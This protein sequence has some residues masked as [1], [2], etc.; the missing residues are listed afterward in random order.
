MLKGVVF[1]EG[2]KTRLGNAAVHNKRTGYTNVTDNFGLFDIQA[3]EGDTL[4][5]S[6]DGY[7]SK[8][9]RVSNLQSLV[10]YL[11]ISSIQLKEVRITGTSEK[12]R[13]KEVESLYRQ[14]GIFYK[15]KPPIGMLSPLGGSPLGYLYE[16]FSKSGREARRLGAY[17]ERESDYNEVAKRFG[18]EKIR[19]AVPIR[20]EDIEEFKSAYWPKNEDV[21]K[22]TDYDLHNYI[23][24]SFE[25]FKK[26]KGY[27]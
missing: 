1:E 7:L 21:R 2:S 13:L 20:E 22:W 26:T 3:Q 6:I 25:E 14:K 19:A 4:Q 12:E 23:R 17:I 10:V 24:K 15:G 16:S 27:M 11:R 8:E 9:L 5:I 18:K